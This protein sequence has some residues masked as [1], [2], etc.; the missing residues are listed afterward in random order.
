MGAGGGWNYYTPKTP[1]HMGQRR[2]NN[3][4][5]HQ[6]VYTS[7][8]A[9]IPVTGTPLVHRP[10]A[11]DYN[12][13]P[14]TVG[15]PQ[16]GLEAS[17]Q[18]D[19]DSILVIDSS[20]PTAPVDSKKKKRLCQRARKKQN[21]NTLTS[22]RTSRNCLLVLLNKVETDYGANL[23]YLWTNHQRCPVT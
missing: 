15:R 20:N 21:K 5:R 13:A 7:R 11:V 14:M 18:A 8:N 16:G 2:L 1:R 17:A 9:L 23:L 19:Y 3:L 12:M 6:E 10:Q 4:A 22:D